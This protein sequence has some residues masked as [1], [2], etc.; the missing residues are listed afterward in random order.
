MY[1]YNKAKE[2]RPERVK[3]VGAFSG[4]LDAFEVLVA[5]DLA[6]GD[7]VEIESHENFEGV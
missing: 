3:R 1:F 5:F 7:G 6:T 2:T 4:K